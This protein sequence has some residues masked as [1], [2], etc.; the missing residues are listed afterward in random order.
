LEGETVVND[1]LH[2]LTEADYLI[3]KFFLGLRTERGIQHLSA[4][5]SV[6][7]PCREEKVKQYEEGGLLRRTT[8]SLFNGMSSNKEETFGLVLTD[9]GMDCYNWIITELLQHL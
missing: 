4:F 5:S 2:L 1:T 3:E 8:S 6:L 9:R 7:I